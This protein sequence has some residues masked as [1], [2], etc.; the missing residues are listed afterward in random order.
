MHDPS[1]LAFSIKYPWWRSTSIFKDGR[2]HRYRDSFID[3]WHE[4]PL[5]FE[6]KVG[7]R[8]DD[9]CGW[10]TPPMRAD[11]IEKWKKIAA[12]QYRQLFAKD[13]AERDGESYARVCYRVPDCYTA[14]YWCWRAIKHEHRRNSW[15]YR[16]PWQYGNRPSASELEVIMNLATNPVDNLQWSF[17]WDAPHEKRDREHDDFWCFFRCVLNAY[18]RHHRP[19]YRHPRWHVH[20]WHIR[21]IPWQKARRVLFSR[22]CRCGGKFRYGEA[23]VTS[24]WDTEKPGWFKSELNIWHSDCDVHG[25]PRCAASSSPAS[26]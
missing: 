6:G 1:T 22:C 21:V 14:V 26:P 20:H 16:Q 10:H 17:V 12:D 13:V 2:K 18:R 9:S 25:A 4:D 11:E 5:K 23:P 19:W 7:C 24:S 8:S 15:W 3:I